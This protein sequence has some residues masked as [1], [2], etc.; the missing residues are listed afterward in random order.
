MTSK[1]TGSG[2]LSEPR[3]QDWGQDGA[4]AR[5]KHQNYAHLFPGM[6]IAL[7]PQPPRGADGKP[8]AGA[9]GVATALRGGGETQPTCAAPVSVGR[10]P[11]GTTSLT[12]RH[13]CAC[14]TRRPCPPSASP[15]PPRL[16]GR[17]GRGRALSENHNFRRASRP[18]PR[19]SVRGAG[20]GAARTPRA[21]PTAAPAGP[22]LPSALPPERRLLQAFAADSPAPRPR[23]AAGAWARRRR[24]RGRSAGARQRH[25]R[26]GGDVPP[27][28]DPQDRHAGGRAPVASVAAVGRG[29]SG[30]AWRAD[31]ARAGDTCLRVG[32]AALRG[33]WTP[34]VGGA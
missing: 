1:V 29:S 27:V 8:Q 3:G 18:K 19:E 31:P 10:R 7:E 2:L 34:G 24:R 6:A 32:F 5:P 20:G 14:G 26:R 17:P 23:G 11:G 33:V 22:G 4:G 25:G 16:N 21:Q 9:R 15:P 30:R 28:E 13:T 12:R